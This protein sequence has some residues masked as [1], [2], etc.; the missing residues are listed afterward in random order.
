MI[1]FLLLSLVSL[2]VFATTHIGVEPE[3]KYD[4]KTYNKTTFEKFN[5]Q[6]LDV[7][8]ENVSFPSRSNLGK[9]QKKKF[10]KALAMLEPVLNSEAFKKRVLSY[11]RPE[12][13]E[14]GYQKNYLWS[15]KNKRLSP[16]QIYD[17]IMKADEKMIPATIGKMNINSWV[18]V[19]KWYER[20]FTWCKKVI[21]STSPSSSKMMK[22]NWKF[23]KSFE[24]HQMVSNIVHEWLHLLGFLHGPSATMR[25][26]VP[27]VVGAIAGEVAKEMIES[28]RK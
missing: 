9:K 11:V 10:V 12:H 6:Y 14:P 24:T 2:S 23:Y 1:K 28:T 17:I 15:N 22:L 27:Y 20:P 3:L 18:K 25:M 5:S 8:I 13:S 26:E 7:I 19:C 16:S 4:K 21:G